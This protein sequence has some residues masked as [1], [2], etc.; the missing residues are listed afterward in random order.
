[1]VFIANYSFAQNK[2]NDSGLKY[3]YWNY[4]GLEEVNYS[5]IPFSCYDTI[6]FDKRENS[7]RGTLWVNKK[8]E[9]RE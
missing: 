4:N 5:I 9:K 7:K 8:M 3:G 2:T 1:M 6:W